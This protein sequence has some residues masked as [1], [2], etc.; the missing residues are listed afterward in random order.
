MATTDWVQKA[1]MPTPTDVANIETFMDNASA[2]ATA[3]AASA[4]EAAASAANALSSEGAVAAS[5]DSA[6][7]S[8]SAASTSAS[9]AA[10]SATNAA[11]S[12]SA[13]AASE[14]NAGT[15]ATNAATSET[16]AA[17][18]ETNAAASASAAATSES[19]ASASETNAAASAS[20]AAASY[21][22]FDDRYLGDKASAPS[23]DNDG[24]PLLTGAIYWDTSVSNLYVYDGAAWQQGAFAPGSSMQDLVDDTTP[25]L[26]GD[27]DLNSYSVTGTG[28]LNITGSISLTGTVDGRDVS[29]DGTKLDGIEALA[30]VT[31]AANVAAAGAVMT[32]DIGS[33][34][35][36]YDADLD[37]WATKTA[38]TGDVVGTSDTQTLTGKTLTAPVIGGTIVETVY[39]IS[40]T[41]PALDPAN[42]SIQTW[43]LTGNSTPTDSVAA[44]EAITLMIDDGTA[45]TI[46]WPT[47]T[48]V[49]NAGSAPTLA[50]AGYTVVALWKVSTTLYGALIGDG[51]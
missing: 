41:T 10:T 45:Y 21:D 4:T 29:V 17:T 40:G 33:T 32:S 18:S 13:A 16:N 11:S 50:T 43:T 24:N 27:L 44:G 42:G 38:P 49:N 25:Q 31:D 39:A 30:D 23:T 20:A 12:A 6:A 5:A 26:G 28:S 8:A 15:S 35:Q 19:N 3:A 14:T 1:G 47:M 34:V 46:T 7:S 22:A 2:S 48:W 36:A 37:T 51:S 9:G